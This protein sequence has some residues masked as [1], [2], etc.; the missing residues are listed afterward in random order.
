[1]GL[2][3]MAVAVAALLLIVDPAHAQSAYGPSPALTAPANGATYSV[4]EDVVVDFTTPR[5]GEGVTGPDVRVSRSPAVDGDG[6][7]LAANSILDLTQYEGDVNAA[8][9]QSEDSDTVAFWAA[10]PADVLL[11]GGVFY[12]QAYVTF[13]HGPPDR[14]RGSAVFSFQVGRSPTAS[15]PAARPA[16]TL[17]VAAKRS[18]TAAR[19]R[20][21]RHGVCAVARASGSTVGRF[22]VR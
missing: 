21:Q 3:W 22:A 11:G 12:W 19:R 8:E 6:V 20:I 10:I 17:R 4:G 15:P 1:M 5:Y 16:L 14:L 13:P 2:F 7:L 18:K 9:G